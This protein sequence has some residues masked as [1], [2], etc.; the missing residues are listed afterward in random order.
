[1]HTVAPASPDPRA[2]TAFRARP[3]RPKCRGGAA[4]VTATAYLKEPVEA[5]SAISP[6][7]C[8]VSPAREPSEADVA[9]PAF[10]AAVTAHGS[11]PCGRLPVNKL[12]ACA[13]SPL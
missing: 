7:V 1:M 3:A 9:F 8:A 5:R 12:T 13:L 6:P 4:A 10:I 11:K 2:R